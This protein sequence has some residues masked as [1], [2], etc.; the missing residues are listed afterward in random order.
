MGGHTADVA[1]KLMVD[2]GC[3][4]VVVDHEVDGF[5]EVVVVNS[6]LVDHEVDGFGEVVVVNSRLVVHPKLKMEIQIV[7]TN[8]K[9]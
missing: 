4:V 3:G 5:G 1:S 9:Q 8:L 6:R 2:V 7:N